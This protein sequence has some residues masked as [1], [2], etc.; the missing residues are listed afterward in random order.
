MEAMSRTVSLSMQSGMLMSCCYILIDFH[1]HILTY[2]NAGHPYPCYYSQKANKLE[3]LLSTDM[4]LGIPGFEESKFTKE[5]RKGGKGDLLV[6]YSDGVTDEE[7]VSEEQY[8]DERLDVVILV[9][10]G[11]SATDI[12]DCILNAL[13]LHCKGMAQ[14]DYVTLIVAKAKK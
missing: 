3:R 8:G 1:N 11:R 4:I 7:N 12:K 14:N 10:I 5:E 6:I 9:N 13:S 2:S